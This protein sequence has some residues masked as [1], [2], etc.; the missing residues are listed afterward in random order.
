MSDRFGEVI[1]NSV[2][3]G[4]LE[5]DEHELRVPRGRAIFADDI[6]RRFFLPEHATM[7][8]GQLLRGDLVEQARRRAAAPADAGL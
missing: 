3:K 6:C 5:F 2:A 8:G 7:M 1:A 4:D